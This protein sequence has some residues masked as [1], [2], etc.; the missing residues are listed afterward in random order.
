MPFDVH[1]RLA[2]S[3]GCVHMFFYPFLG[4]F[5]RVG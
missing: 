4:G 5:E 3:S 1:C 2:Q